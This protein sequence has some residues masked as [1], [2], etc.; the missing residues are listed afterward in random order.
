LVFVNMPL[1]YCCRG[2]LVP[3]YKWELIG[4]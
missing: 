2:L 4:G 3:S 1:L